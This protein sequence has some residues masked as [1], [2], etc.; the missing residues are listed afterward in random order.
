MGDIVDITDMATK[1]NDL[2]SEQLFKVEEYAKSLGFKVSMLSDL[3][4]WA[5]FSPKYSGKF[6]M[7]HVYYSASLPKS[8]IPYARLRVA[9]PELYTSLENFEDFIVYATVAH[10]IAKIIREVGGLYV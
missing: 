1:I 2:T 5:F 7:I 3:T 9:V 8:G 4:D 10:N 6:P